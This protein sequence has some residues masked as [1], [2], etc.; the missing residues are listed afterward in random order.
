MESMMPASVMAE[1]AAAATA[2]PAGR[3]IRTFDRSAGR[4]QEKDQ[5]A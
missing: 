3:L 5:Q 2:S 1:G 4:L